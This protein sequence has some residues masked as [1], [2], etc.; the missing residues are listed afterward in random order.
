LIDGEASSL[1]TT[2]TFKF[3][4]V[5][6]YVSLTN[7]A[8]SAYFLVTSTD[9][10]KTIPPDLQA[11]IERNNA[12]YA[13]LVHRDI[14]LFNASTA[15]KLTRQGMT[16]NTVEQEPFRARLRA[17]YQTWASHFGQQPWTML[18]SA[19]GRKLA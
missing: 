1:V 6:K 11:I 8:W 10:W 15:D 13:A 18:E 5:L 16:V 3:F 19:I 9:Y 2:E 4:E 7:H 12:K 14:T 17:Y